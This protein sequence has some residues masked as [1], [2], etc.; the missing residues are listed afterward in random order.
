MYYKELAFEKSIIIKRV[1]ALFGAFIGPE[2]QFCPGMN[3]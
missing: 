3:H 1:F 2:I